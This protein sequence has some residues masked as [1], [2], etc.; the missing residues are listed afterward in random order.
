MAMGMCPHC[1]V[2]YR[3]KRSLTPIHGYE[4]QDCPGSQQNPRNPDSDARLLWNGK[5]NKHFK[6]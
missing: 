6:G 2:I 4:N 1:G 3:L 5:L